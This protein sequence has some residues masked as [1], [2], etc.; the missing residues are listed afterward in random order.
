MEQWR[1]YV[2]QD[3]LLFLSSPEKSHVLCPYLMLRFIFFYFTSYFALQVFNRKL[4]TENL[5][6]SY[7]ISSAV[8]TREDSSQLIF[9]LTS[10]LS[11]LSVH[12]EIFIYDKLVVLSQRKS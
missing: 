9:L 5:V 12:A 7:I 11:F 1:F 6:A 10:I 2:L 8:V 3:I 4:L